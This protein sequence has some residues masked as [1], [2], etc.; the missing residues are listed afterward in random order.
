MFKHTSILLGALVLTAPVYAETPTY[1][2]IDF[3]TDV[4]KEIANDLLSATLSVELNNKNPALLAKEL[5]TVTNES[6]KLG[7]GYSSVKLTSGNQQ[8]YPIYND[9]NKLDGWRGRAEIQVSSKD[10]KAAGELISQLQAKLQLNNLNFTVAPETRRELENQLISEA[11]AAFR[12]RA[13][14]IKNAWNA[15]SY[16]LVQM[17]LGTTNNQQ[18]QPMYMVRAAK[19]EMADA[20][21]AAD[22]AGGQSRLNVQVSGSIELEN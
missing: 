10:F 19:M 18:P 12:A 7:S 20:A 2:R 4:E 16:K 14:K 5:T 13:D 3:Q 21:P 6:L 15:K 11:V 22:Y 8:T 1:Q 9:K 17:N